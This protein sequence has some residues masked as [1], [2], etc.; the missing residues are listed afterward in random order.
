MN[1]SRH[2]LMTF[3]GTW[4]CPV[5]WAVWIR[6]SFKKRSPTRTKVWREEPRSHVPSSCGKLMSSSQNH[7][8]QLDQVLCVPIPTHRKWQISMLFTVYF[9]AKF[10]WCSPWLV[11]VPMW[12]MSSSDFP[13]D[14]QLLMFS[15]HQEVSVWPVAVDCVRRRRNISF[16]RKTIPHWGHK[17][18][19]K[20]EKVSAGECFYWF[21]AIAVWGVDLL[22]PV[23]LL[24]SRI[25]FQVTFSARRTEASGE[26]GLVRSVFS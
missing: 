1:T 24:I 10:T 9:S 2:R 7:F 22:L 16:N 26:R 14:D 20:I 12:K 11:R 23:V 21:H 6:K 5:R 17:L 15:S 4:Q 3:T 19:E 13:Q 25:L 8:R 18:S